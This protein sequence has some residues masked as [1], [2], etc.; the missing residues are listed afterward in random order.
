MKKKKKKKKKKMKHQF[1]AEN[2]IG[3]TS[4]G[5]KIS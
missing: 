1:A 3:H 4:F 5:H 2:A